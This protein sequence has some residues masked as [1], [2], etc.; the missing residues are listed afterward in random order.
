MHGP[1]AAGSILALAAVGQDASSRP[2]ERRMHWECS[3][4]HAYTGLLSIQ[5]SAPL[6]PTMRRD[7]TDRDG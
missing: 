7:T 1:A 5:L 6:R 4:I 2:L 3:L